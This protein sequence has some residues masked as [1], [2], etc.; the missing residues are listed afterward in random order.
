MSK[1]SVLTGHCCRSRLTC[2]ERGDEEP[3][4]LY[5]VFRGGKPAEFL[6]GIETADGS[7]SLN[8]SRFKKPR[9]S[10]AVKR[11]GEE[12]CVQRE[13]EGIRPTKR[14]PN[15]RLQ[16][17]ARMAHSASEQS[18]ATRSGPSR[19]DTVRSFTRRSPPHH[20]SR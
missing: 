12:R 18:T 11:R 6:K 13:E 16:I 1:A 8:P 19:D 7:F 10:S 3:P 14:T 20:S 5:L 15:R 17:E 9:G 2:E 4:F